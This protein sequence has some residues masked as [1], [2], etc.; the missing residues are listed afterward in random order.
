MASYLVEGRPSRT[1]E[2]TKWLMH[3]D[4]PLWHRLM[5][6]LVQHAAASIISQLAN[7]ARAFQLFDSWA[8]ALS[9]ADYDHF[10]L[11]HSQAVFAAVRGAHHATPSISRHSAALSAI[12]VVAPAETSNRPWNQGNTKPPEFPIVTIAAGA[13]LERPWA[14]IAIAAGQIGP[15]ARPVA[16][17]ATTARA[18]CSFAAAIPPLATIPPAM[19]PRRTVLAGTPFEKSAPETKRPA[20]SA[21]Q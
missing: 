2:H 19:L 3:T 9:K 11:R 10:V 18:R 6:A 7:G 17:A 15:K 12:P 21:P 1:Y 14:A 5:E 20:I 8:G 13:L 4:E 16:N